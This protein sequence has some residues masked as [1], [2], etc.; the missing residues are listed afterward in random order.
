MRQRAFEIQPSEHPA[1]GPLFPG[2]VPLPCQGGERVKE[3]K[4]FSNGKQETT[5]SKA[6]VLI[7]IL[8]GLILLVP[9]INRGAETLHKIRI[10]FPSLAFSYMPFYVAYETGILKKH[11]LEAENIKIRNTIQQ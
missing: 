8:D 1:H 6:T 2:F 5:I 10:G 4:D 11:G 9:E 7:N 3:E